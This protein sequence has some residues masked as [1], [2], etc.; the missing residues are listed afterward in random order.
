[1]REAVTGRG[2]LAAPFRRDVGSSAST[3]PAHVVPT[4]G[5]R[6]L[7]AALGAAVVLWTGTAATPAHAV[8]GTAPSMAAAWATVKLEI[9]GNP[10]VA[11][12]ELRE[13]ACS[14]A[15]LNASWVISAAS[16]FAET[17]GGEVSAGPP[18]WETKATV[19]RFES[20]PT[21]GPMGSPGRT[22]VAPG[23]VVDVDRV[24]PHPEHDVVLLHLAAPVAGGAVNLAETA[25]SVGDV[26]TVTGFG[27]TADEIV[28]KTAHAAT[29]T[30]A[31]VGAE[32]LDIVAS[33]DGATICKGDAGGPALRATADRGI[34]L[35]AIHHTAYQG[36]CLGATSTRQDATETRVDT[37][38]PW[39]A[40][41]IAPPAP[42][43]KHIYTVNGGQVYEAASN[44]GWKSIN[45]LISTSGPV[46]ALTVDG[47]KYVYTVNG[48]Q[49]YEAASNNGWKNQSTGVTSSGALAVMAMDGVKYIYTVNGGQVHEA[50]SN[51]GWK[52]QNSMIPAPGPIAALSA[53][54][55]KYVYTVHGGHVY[56]AASNTG[57]KNI[58]SLVSTAGPLAVAA[59]Q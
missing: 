32:A 46:A 41:N 5:V 9:A 25:P 37:I 2:R 55:V 24:V 14:G 16:C 49:V 53:D 59:L 4:T 26:L 13:R 45:S 17:P 44:N 51:N 56:E 31:G 27:R 7:I 21:T 1:M 8:Q 40:E 18:M 35:V 15:L 48:G 22:V 6:A 50:A 23:K 34:E 58:D 20:P 19:G 38:R 3:R 36:G 30:V 52:N 39:I 42:P 28:P 10:Q 12:G 33:E 57:W 11:P 47:V 29:Y 43:V 54:G